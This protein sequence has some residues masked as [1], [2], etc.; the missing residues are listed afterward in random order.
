MKQYAARPY[1]IARDMSRLPAL[2]HKAITTATSSVGDRLTSIRSALHKLLAPKRQLDDAPQATSTMWERLIARLQPRSKTE[3][4]P[5]IVKPESAHPYYA[6]GDNDA[7]LDL[8]S[9]KPRDQRLAEAE[10]S[11][12]EGLRGYRADRIAETNLPFGTRPRDARSA[13]MRYG[14]GG[15]TPEAGAWGHLSKL[16]REA[17]MVP[18]DA[19]QR[20]YGLAG[21]VGAAGAGSV[22][23]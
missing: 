2:E 14:Y 22:S 13:Y 16:F 5:R 8:L 3:L 19:L 7:A 11:L 21:A 4:E 6:S 12:F 23:E 10:Q 18:R 9:T 1:Q 15:Y 17:G 20:Y